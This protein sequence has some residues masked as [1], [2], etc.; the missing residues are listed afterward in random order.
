[1]HHIRLDD[2]D[3][4][5]DDVDLIVTIIRSGSNICQKHFSPYFYY[6]S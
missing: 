2:D 4:G 6:T 1:M 3:G 5:G